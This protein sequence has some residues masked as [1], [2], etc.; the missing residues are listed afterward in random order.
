MDETLSTIC[1]L[2]AEAFGRRARTEAE[3]LDWALEQNII[4]P[5]ERGAFAIAGY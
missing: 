3:A 2:F 5:D 1:A 4:R